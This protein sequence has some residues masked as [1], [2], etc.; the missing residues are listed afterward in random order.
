MRTARVVAAAVA[1][2]LAGLLPADAE[3]PAW[4]QWQHVAGIFDVGGPRADGRLVLATSG[5]LALA[6]MQG[7]LSSFAVGPG[8]YADDAGTEAYLAVSPG[9]HDATAGC[10]FVRDDVFVLRLHQPLGVTRVD[11]SGQARP[12]AAVTGVESL[13]GIAFDTTGRFGFRLLVSGPI[14]GRT[15]VVSIDCQGRAQ[16]VTNMAPV[17]EGG[18]AVAPAGF[19]AFAGAL[20]APDELSGRIYAI[21]PD[22]AVRTVATSGLATGGDIGV[23][24]V[25][26]VPPGFTRG[27]WA[28]YADRGTPG[29]PHPGTDSLLRLN[30]HDLVQL[31]VRDGDL[32]AA[33]EGGA[34]VEAVRCAATCQV[35]RLIAAPSVAHGEGHLVLV[36]TPAGA[37]PATAPAGRGVLDVGRIAAAAS[38]VAALAALVLLFILRA[39]RRRR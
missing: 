39:A 29:N 24:S 38:L 1:L 14:K 9:L 2:L 36:A 4:G 10:D 3:G 7:V 11:G 15:A 37:P 26:F 32:L 17:L 25:G 13:N 22:G 34:G 23:E 35:T 16:M 5:R 6:D 28:Y 18:L 33:T 20:I 19:G 31:G 12:F 8:G 27:G 30:A 21:T